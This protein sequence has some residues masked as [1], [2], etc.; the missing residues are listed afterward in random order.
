MFVFL[1]QIDDIAS[2]QAKFTS[3]TADISNVQADIA[4]NVAN[5]ATHD[6]DIATNA[7]NIATHNAYIATNAAN[8]ATHDTDIAT[9]AVNIATHDTD[10]A[11]NAANIASN[12]VEITNINA[13][14]LSNDIYRQKCTVN[15]T[16]YRMIN[17]KC[18]YYE[19]SIYNYE[20]AKQ[21]CE[22]RFNNNGRL[23]EPKTWNENEVAFKIGKQ[24]FGTPNWWVG[25][26][27]E[28]NEGQFVFE[29]DGTPISY[30]PTWYVN[31]GTKG[32]IY[33]CILF[34]SED[35][36]VAWLDWP[37]STSKYKS[38]CEQTNTL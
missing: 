35:G 3:I 16:N 31:Y 14:I 38:I 28:E 22:A 34:S 25:I 4:T 29:S 23:F 21:N 24:S 19:S 17:N 13:Q 27:D 30:S 15:E 37:C 9:N 8:I 20:D 7:A 33:N 10:I 18:V 12:A 2:N 1:F 36:T 32:T 6:A 11:T 26:T 5:I